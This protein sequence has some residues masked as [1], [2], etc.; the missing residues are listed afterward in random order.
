MIV[1][2]EGNIGAGKSTLLA[3]L[4]KT[5]LGN[6]THI[7]FLDEPLDVWSKVE[8]QRPGGPGMQNLLDAF[9]EDPTQH[10]FAF[11]VLAQ[12]SRV[13]RLRKAMGWAQII[14]MERSPRS[15]Q[16]IFAAN[17]KDCGAICEMHHAVYKAC[18]DE[19][20]KLVPLKTLTVYLKAPESV[21]LERIKERAR[22]GEVVS[23]TYLRQLGQ[24]HE[25]IFGTDEEI[26]HLDGSDTVE[27][28]VDHVLA[29]CSH[30]VDQ[31]GIRP[32]AYH[33][34]AK[35]LINVIWAVG[36][37]MCGG[38]LCIILLTVIDIVVEE[39]AW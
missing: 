15:D 19:L 37:L 9:Y 7:E 36:G 12:V 3:A 8:A 23:L 35:T 20:S 6:H 2:I 25:R 18:C 13:S 39:F 34:G 4:R 26:L 28:N 31:R 21:L 29:W 10:A 24:L 5:T 14:I 16:D 32:D 38:F 27:Q 33:S 11:Q 17:M 22:P 1:A 30:L